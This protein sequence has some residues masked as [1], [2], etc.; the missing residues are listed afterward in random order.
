VGKTVIIR[1]LIDNVQ[2]GHGG[3]SVFCGVGERSL[4]GGRRGT[5]RD[6]AQQPGGVVSHGMM[7]VP[8]H[9]S[10]RDPERRPDP[11]RGEDGDPQ[12]GGAS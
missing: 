6:E 1:E 8:R 11:D 4:V 7:L 10:P 9:I 5:G 2:K 12:A 3:R